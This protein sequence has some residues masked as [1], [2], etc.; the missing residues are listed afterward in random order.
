[1][2]NIRKILTP[3]FVRQSAAG[4]KGASLP[5]TALPKSAG[6]AARNNKY[7]VK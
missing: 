7:Q 1:M 6:T 2:Q 5:K 4:R 3:H